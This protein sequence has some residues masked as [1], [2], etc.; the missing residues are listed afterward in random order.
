M[1]GEILKRK[2]ALKNKN[3]IK[4]INFSSHDMIVSEIDVYA[5]KRVINHELD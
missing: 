5:A 3:D 1:C 2:Y 4:K